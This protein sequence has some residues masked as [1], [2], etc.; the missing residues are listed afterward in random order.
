M[1]KLMTGAS[2]VCLSLL[3]SISARGQTPTP[4]PAPPASDIFL[5]DVSVQA[6][7]L[8]FGP[9]V[10]ITD[11]DGYNNQPFFLADGQSLLFTSIRDKQADIY[12]YDIKTR[13]TTR[14]TDTPESE[15]SPTLT[16]DGK[17][18]SVVRVEADGT[19]RLWKFP[20]AGGKP[21]LVLEK[22]KPVGYHTWIDENT[23]A[24]YVLGQPNSLQLV[25]V[26]TEKAEVIVEKIGRTVRRIPGE[27][28]IAFVHRLTDE[29]WVIKSYDLKTKAI[30]TLIKTLPLSE[31][32]AWTPSGM[33]VISKNSKLLSW[34]PG[35]PDWQ[36]QVDFSEAGLKG[37]TRIAISPR[38]DR[39]ALVVRRAGN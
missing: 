15:F 26:K 23:V 17:F 34:T 11:W 29:E 13:A 12:R 6:G 14:I 28:K 3:F 31:D 24:L 27:D 33:L 37:I 32:F 30:S 38:G 9:P 2:L 7:Q 35:Q 1:K 10:K 22:I 25:D 4:S 39:V 8:K 21:V 16:P 18:I 19:Q 36:P 20:L 5:L